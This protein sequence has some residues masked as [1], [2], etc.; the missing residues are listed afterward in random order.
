M[1]E[2][3][4]AW[5]ITRRYRARLLVIF[6]LGAGTLD[7]SALVGITGLSPARLYRALESLIAAG[8]VAREHTPT[9]R[10]PFAYRLVVAS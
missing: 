3:I 9:A 2:F 5:V 7:L 4:R 1:P 8:L 10:L 6:A